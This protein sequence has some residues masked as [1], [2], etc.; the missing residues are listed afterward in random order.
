[1]WRYRSVCWVGENSTIRL[2]LSQSNTTWDSSS[3]VSFCLSVEE[4][5]AVFFISKSPSLTHTLRLLHNQSFSFNNSFPSSVVSI[6]SKFIPYPVLHPA[7]LT[8]VDALSQMLLQS[9]MM[10]IVRFDVD[11][12]A[13]DECTWSLELSTSSCP[14]F[15][16]VPGLLVLLL[17]WNRIILLII[18]RCCDVHDKEMCSKDTNTWVLSAG[19]FHPARCDLLMLLS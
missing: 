1:M 13:L 2:S 18:Q 4:H 12:M 16:D 11:Q 10:K 19:T 7:L 17:L 8:C 5:Q 14:A 6:H 9:W 15:G 3:S